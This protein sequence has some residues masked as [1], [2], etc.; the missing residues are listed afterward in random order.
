M[1][2][3]LEGRIFLNICEESCKTHQEIKLIG[4]LTVRIFRPL[5]TNIS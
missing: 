5:L 4:I 3:F 2:R 1:L